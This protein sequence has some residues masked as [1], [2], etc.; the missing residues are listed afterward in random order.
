MR[1][2]YVL[3]NSLQVDRTSAVGG[4]EAALLRHLLAQSRSWEVGIFR[5]TFS[6]A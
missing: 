1:L 6:Y 2:N 3:I 5:R 4:Q